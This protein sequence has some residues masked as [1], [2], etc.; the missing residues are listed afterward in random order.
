MRV[1]G[2]GLGFSILVVSEPPQG[3]TPAHPPDLVLGHGLLDQVLH[4]LLMRDDACSD[5]GQAPHGGTCVRG[6]G[7]A[8]THKHSCLSSHSHSCPSP[9]SSL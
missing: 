1:E 6:A 2:L 3:S 9:N 8:R 4:K 7:R 5:F